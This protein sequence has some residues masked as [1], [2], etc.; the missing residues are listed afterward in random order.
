MPRF[1]SKHRARL[2]CR[3]TT[4]SFGLVRDRRHVQLPVIGVVRTHEST[5]KPAR[6]VDDGTA[7]IRSATLSFQRGRWHVRLSVEVSD[8][9]SRAWR[10][11]AATAWLTSTLRA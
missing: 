9:P 8:P 5:R 10:A 11:N 2:S 3:F 4:G 7:R 6:K 1:K